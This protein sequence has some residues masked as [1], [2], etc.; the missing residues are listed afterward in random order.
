MADEVDKA[1]DAL[2]AVTD[3]AT[4][5]T[6]AITEVPAEATS[7]VVAVSK[8][9]LDASNALIHALTERVTHLEGSVGELAKTPER[10]VETVAEPPPVHNPATRESWWQR[11]HRAI[12]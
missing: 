1:G 11:A 8:D 2:E 12:R 7:E 5:A 4:D 3:A 6:K 10:V 9:A